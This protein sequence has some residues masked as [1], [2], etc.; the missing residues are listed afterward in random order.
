MRKSYI[1]IWNFAD[2]INP[3]LVLEAPSEVH[4]FKFHPENKDMIVAGCSNGQVLV[5]ELKE[6][7]EQAMLRK[8]SGCFAL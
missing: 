5:Y 2:Q 6:A 4:A 7:R 8:V 1:L 3:E